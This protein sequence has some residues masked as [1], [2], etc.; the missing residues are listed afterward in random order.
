MHN[1]SQV[2][3]IKL[4]KTQHDISIAHTENIHA[5]KQE[6]VREYYWIWLIKTLCSPLNDSCNYENYE[7]NSGL[8][9]EWI[10]I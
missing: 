7:D 5:N 8:F 6:G 2:Q 10:G 3:V 1:P 4:I 9:S